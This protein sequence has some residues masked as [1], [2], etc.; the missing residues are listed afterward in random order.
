V[1]LGPEAPLNSTEQMVP[2]AANF[3]SLDHHSFLLTG[4]SV[5]SYILHSA[6]PLPSSPH[7]KVQC[8][9]LL[10]LQANLASRP[11]S[12]LP[13]HLLPVASSPGDHVRQHRPPSRDL[14][15]G[16][17]LSPWGRL[18]MFPLPEPELPSFTPTSP[19]PD[20]FAHV[21]SPSAPFPQE[22]A[23]LPKYVLWRCPSA[24][25]QSWGFTAVLTQHVVTDTKHHHPPV[26]VKDP[27]HLCTFAF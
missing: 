1:S 3:L 18:V 16:V 10:L 21:Q 2:Q 12:R 25:I 14:R 5:S 6:A 4:D 7:N 9:L 13:E 26:A 17:L 24:C 27:S 15:S 22:T 19:G 8:L 20:L 23:L 11:H